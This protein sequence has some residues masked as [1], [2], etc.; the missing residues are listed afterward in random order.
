MPWEDPIH[1]YTKMIY[2]IERVSM[3]LGSD[4]EDGQWINEKVQDMFFDVGVV[5]MQDFLC[6]VLVINTK[7]QEAGHPQL[8]LK[9][10][11]MMMKEVSDMWE[12]G[13]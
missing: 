5:T 2:M 11:N 3:K 6:N 7:L 13:P 8:P 12:H 4:V 1:R 10:L 9:T